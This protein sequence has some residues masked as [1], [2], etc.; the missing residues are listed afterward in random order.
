MSKS[1]TS[2]NKYNE[3]LEF[4]N[5]QL[6]LG[7]YAQAIDYYE[8]LAQLMPVSTSKDSMLHFNMAN[9]Y[10]AIKQYDKAQECYLK[11]ITLNTHLELS[12]KSCLY[13]INICKFSEQYE[14]I[15][16]YRDSMLALVP[17]ID[18]SH[19]KEDDNYLTNLLYSQGEELFNSGNFDKALKF[20]QA[21]DN[22]YPN[23]QRTFQYQFVSFNIACTYSELEQYSNA[24]EYYNKACTQIKS[25]HI[26]TKL[27]KEKY[28][29]IC[30]H[31]ALTYINLQDYETAEKYFKIVTE[32]DPSHAGANLSY[33]ELLMHLGDYQSALGFLYKA[34]ELDYDNHSIHTNIIQNY[35][36]LHK[37]DKVLECLADTIAI[38][39]T[40][41]KNYG[42]Y[43]D[44]HDGT[45]QKL[46]SDIRQQS[47]LP[48][49]DLQ[50][51]CNMLVKINE[52]FDVLRHN[53]GFNYPGI[54][55]SQTEIINLLFNSAQEL[56]NANDFAEALKHFQIIEE[57]NTDYQR[58]P[59]YQPISFCMAYTLQQLEQYSEAIGYYNKALVDNQNIKTMLDAKKYVDTCYNLAL[60]HS[61][62]QDYSQAIEYFQTAIQYDQTNV[63][64]YKNCGY[65]LCLSGQYKK[66]ALFFEQ[67][68]KLA[69]DNIELY[70]D[71]AVA[72]VKSG[73]S[74]DIALATACYQQ[75]LTLLPDDAYEA[76][77]A[78][79]NIL[80]LR[81]AQLEQQQSEAQQNLQLKH[82]LLAQKV[83]YLNK[84][85]ALKA[86]DLEIMR[87][88]DN[89]LLE[90]VQIEQMIV[91]YNADTDMAVIGEAN[92]Y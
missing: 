85:L 82:D 20:Y 65:A 87:I 27:D 25:K 15:N 55:E 28:A 29:D 81:I 42:H 61:G 67:A 63:S 6:S 10:E 58:S 47:K 79:G 31:V 18:L 34:R 39:T 86:D 66:A 68:I 33:A 51:Q 1:N 46:I 26:I 24:L 8:E 2:N 38:L 54:I 48:P 36:K 59:E 17:E 76:H 56:F 23:Y 50:L 7:N 9:A 53:L 80:H 14:K 84:I 71:K 21:I 22:V 90:I 91:Q 74:E 37:I 35:C 40:G 32:Y 5:L 45:Y 78:Q 19:F 75:V 77:E 11:V 70:F 3:Y 60:A 57:F 16:E 44:Q 41:M 43:S 62:L 13:A 83:E 88:R 30:Y 4:I 69:P 73:G 92:Q 64:A 52:C 12:A 72:L 49:N 89:D